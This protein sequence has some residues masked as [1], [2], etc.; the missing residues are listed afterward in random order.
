MELETED[1]YIAEDL[2]QKEDMS[3]DLS[4]GEILTLFQELREES[5]EDEYFRETALDIERA[6]KSQPTERLVSLNSYAYLNAQQKISLQILQNLILT[7]ASLITKDRPS[8]Y[9]VPANDSLEAT[10]YAKIATKFLEYL[11]N[12][13]NTANKYH[14]TAIWAATHGTGLMHVFYDPDKKRVEC[15]PLTIFDA[16]LENRAQPDDVGWAMIRQYI[17]PYEAKALLRKVDEE[18][19]EPPKVSYIDI[20]NKSRSA[21]EKWIIYIKPGERVKDGLYACIVNNVVVE[22]SKFPYVFPEADGQ[23]TKAILPLHWFNW[24]NNAGLTLGSTFAKDCVS[25]QQAIDL[26]MTKQATDAIEARQLLILPTSMKD[27]DFLDG[28]RAILYYDAQSGEAPPDY[29]KPAPLDPNVQSALKNFIDAMYMTS[30]ISQSTTGDANANQSGKALAYQAELDA[31]KH[32]DAFRNFE[33]FQENIGE[34]KLKIIQKFY[35]IEQQEKILGE[36]AALFNSADLAGVTVKI[37]RRSERDSTQAVKIDNAKKD[38]TGN[39]AGREALLDAAPNVTTGAQLHWAQKIIKDFLATGQTPDITSETIAPEIMIKAIDQELNA[40]ELKLDKET[41]ES[42]RIFKDEYLQMVASKQEPDSTSVAANPQQQP[43]P[44][45]T[46]E[47]PL[48]TAI[49]Q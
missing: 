24:R 8:V 31:T 30:G 37:E 16:W 35:K 1:N 44:E 10:M 43:L 27:K 2:A 19:R 42:L 40:A 39:F 17:K 7:G 33:D 3:T 36:S 38:M 12:E 15:E 34:N 45:Q 21:V 5:N 11:E 48:P 32:A 23:T 13:D 26:L 9:G 20:N 46:S 29:A 41:V 49:K 14:K 18:A 22:A 47:E 4:D 6:S 25:L 28:E